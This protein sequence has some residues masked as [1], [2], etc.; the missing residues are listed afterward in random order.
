MKNACYV[1]NLTTKYEQAICT[2][3]LLQNE[4][5]NEIS[6]YALFKVLMHSSEFKNFE[7]F[8]IS[9]IKSLRRTLSE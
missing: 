2:H 7:I 9:R 1:R 4:I 5:F 8:H 3:K 6:N